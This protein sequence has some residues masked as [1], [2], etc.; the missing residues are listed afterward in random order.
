MGGFQ[1]LTLKDHNVIIRRN[2]FESS[3]SSCP[4]L[5]HQLTRRSWT[6]SLTWATRSRT[7]SGASRCPSKSSWRMSLRTRIMNLTR[8]VLKAET[9]TAVISDT[10]ISWM[11]RCTFQLRE[12][13][14]L[15]PRWAAKFAPD[16][17]RAWFYLD[18]VSSTFF[19]FCG[20]L[21]QLKSSK[22]FFDGGFPR[23]ML[24]CWLKKNWN[25]LLICKYKKILCNRYHLC[26]LGAEIRLVSLRRS[27][28]DKLS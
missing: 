1:T 25:V 28:F 14:D 9:L 7:L 16:K 15:G 27:P 12:Y 4:L 11:I 2:S 8:W 17:I 6:F 23:S 5:P 3:N 20:C 13:R 19:F 18:P 21:Q 24:P 10:S 22:T 26:L